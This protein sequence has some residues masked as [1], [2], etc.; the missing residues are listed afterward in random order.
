MRCFNRVDS[1]ELLGERLRVLFIF[2]TSKKAS[3]SILNKY[4]AKY[5]D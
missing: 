4:K 5:E 2:V 1:E 3:S